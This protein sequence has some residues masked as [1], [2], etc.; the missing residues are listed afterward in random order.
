M[1]KLLHDLLAGSAARKPDHPAV[2]CRN[3]T[4]AYAELDI[5]SGRLARVLSEAGVRPGDRVAILMNKSVD[6]L[7]AIYGIMKAGA[8]YV[9]LD[10][11]SPPQRQAFVL[12]DCDVRCVVSEPRKRA[13][14]VAA[15]AA[16]AR[17]TRVFGVAAGPD[18]AGA[19]G[20]WAALDRGD[21]L[22]VP[23]GP[24][25]LCYVLY[26]SGSTGT[27]K[28]I[29]HTH[30]S[31]TAWAETATAAFGLTG[32]D[33]L[34]NYAPLHFDLSTLDLFGSALLGATMVM[35]PEEYARLP[36]SMAGL[37][38]SERVTVFYTVPYALIQLVLHGGLERHD[39][40]ALRWVLFGGE[41]MSVKHLAALMS[42]WPGA[43]FA[44]VYGPTETNGCTYYVLPGPPDGDAAL[45]IGR[46]NDG[47]ERL[48]VDDD[49]DPVAPGASGELLIRAPT[50]MR[51]YWNRPDL[52]ARVFFDPGDGR[53]NFVRTGDVVRESPD[54]V[55]EFLGRRDRLIK[56][57]GNR[58]ELDDVEAVL[59]AC[60]FVEEAAVFAR[61]DA[62]GSL[63]IHAAATLLEGAEAGETELRRHLKAHLPPYAQ[64]VDLEIHASFPRTATGKID[65]RRL[66]AGENEETSSR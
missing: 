24:E 42:R 54:G 46:L 65:R 31:A 43:R 60:E 35:I 20:D 6:C 62:A 36:A 61:P 11:T 41:P 56:S 26:T 8:A 48:I 29:M 38:A 66:C 1:P 55:L 30:A 10:P 2:V 37:L 12:N 40:G 58:V 49:L 23:S 28:G 63:V 16:G 21:S 39:F 15:M 52:N 4:L 53:G 64:P 27:P 7:T 34:S 57:R 18:L 9:P 33:R 22:T 14:C 50:A 45:P 3:Q 25:D 32:D 44:N 51:G 59:A 17:V 47:A 5:R 13:Q 19:I